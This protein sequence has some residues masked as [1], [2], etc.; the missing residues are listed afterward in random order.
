[1]QKAVIIHAE[2]IHK[3][4]IEHHE[5]LQRPAVH[6]FGNLVITSNVKCL[7]LSISLDVCV[8]KKN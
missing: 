8:L 3:S 1:M 5:L 6:H 7:I 4:S 2:G